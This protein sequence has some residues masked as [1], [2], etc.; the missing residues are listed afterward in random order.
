MLRL[1]TLAKLLQDTSSSQMNKTSQRHSKISVIREST[2]A[3]RIA[4]RLE[5]PSGSK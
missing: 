2:D 1:I 3:N 4:D 5:K